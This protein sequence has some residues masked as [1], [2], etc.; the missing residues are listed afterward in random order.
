MSAIEVE[1]KFLGVQSPRH[2]H[3]LN[4]KFSIKSVM[5]LNENNY[6]VIHIGAGSKAREWPEI[7]WKSLSKKL[8]KENANKLKLSFNLEFVLEFVFL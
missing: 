7:K 4:K 1:T 5:D 3:T 6:L 2:L 8:I